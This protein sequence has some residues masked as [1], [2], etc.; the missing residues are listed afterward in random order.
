MV[1]TL[2]PLRNVVCA[3]PFTIM[4]L[5]TDDCL[6]PA[7]RCVDAVVTETFKIGEVD[8]THY[9]CPC[10]FASR[11]NPE[12]ARSE[13]NIVQ[14]RQQGSCDTDPTGGP[15]PNCVDNENCSSITT[16]V[17]LESDNIIQVNPLSFHSLFMV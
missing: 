6:A 3:R 17:L 4:L 11:G 12:T 1:P 2:L 14:A 16:V 7:S 10:A 13:A 5:H 8:I 15:D 9:N